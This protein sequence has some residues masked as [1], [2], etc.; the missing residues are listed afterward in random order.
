MGNINQFNFIARYYDQLIKFKDDDLVMQLAKLPVE[1]WLLDV[2]GGTGRV[3]N[4]FRQSVDQVEILD[5]SFQMLYVASNKDLKVVCG[6]GS[7]IPHKN[8]S[9]I[10]VL[11]IDAL[12]HCQNQQEVISEMWRV[13]KP[14][15][16]M[17]ILEPDISTISGKLIVLME[18][19]LIMRSKFFTNEDL[20]GQLQKLTNSQIKLNYSGGSS[21]FVVNKLEK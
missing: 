17:M 20:F 16:L 12:H 6:D 21:I 1:G 7:H 5:V 9:F 13:L 4:A 8:E 3:T 15:G 10:R 14:G 18:K 19:I 11:L 2:G